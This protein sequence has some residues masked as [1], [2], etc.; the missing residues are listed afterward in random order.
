VQ[1]LEQ[2]VV[3]E[4]GVVSQINQV[5]AVYRRDDEE[6]IFR[7]ARKHLAGLP[8]SEVQMGDAPVIQLPVRLSFP[9]TTAQVVA[10]I[11]SALGL[12][13]DPVDRA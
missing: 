7:A 3:H 13:R 9:Y 1:Y 2:L 6:Q 12:C 10:H 4:A 5:Q 8:R 11:E